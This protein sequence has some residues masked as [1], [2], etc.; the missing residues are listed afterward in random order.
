MGK[1]PLVKMEHIHKWFEKV[2]A[3]NDVSLE[4]YPGE[5]IGLIGDNGAGKSTLIKILSGIHKPDKG[6]IFINGKNVKIPSV[7]DARGFGIETVFQ[8]QAVV[9]DL[10]IEK[11]I[12]LSRELTKFK[13][14]FTIIDNKKT[15]EE[16]TKLM[17]E[18]V[19]NI[20]TGQEV[21]FC[22]GGEK[23][24]VAIARAMQF[25]A[26]LVIL[27]EPTTALSIKGVE[28]VLKFI[29]KMKE[30]GITSILISHS[31]HYIYPVAS[32]FVILSKGKKIADIQKEKTSM[33]KIERIL[34]GLS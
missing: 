14:P 7:K 8:E 13:G 18:L 17:R 6:K 5:I 1:K 4:I 12:F 9:G 26:K 21:R 20:D 15:K 16:A 31:L 32:R 33:A 19:L 29:K 28:Q 34:K 22:S 30:K 24:G 27:D 3:V 25:D 23:Q 10:S 2:Y 11:N